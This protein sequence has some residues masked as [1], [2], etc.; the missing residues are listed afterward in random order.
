MVFMPI[1]KILPRNKGNISTQDIIH[2]IEALEHDL[3][4]MNTLEVYLKQVIQI[5]KKLNV[6]QLNNKQN[7]HT[8]ERRSSEK[9][10]IKNLEQ[11]L[12]LYMQNIIKQQLDPMQHS[13]EI[14]TEKVVHLEKRLTTLEKLTNKNIAMNE[15]MTNQ[16]NKLCKKCSEDGQP[17]IYQ[18][19]KIEKFFVDQYTQE[20]NLGNI[21]IRELSGHLNIGTTYQNH[22]SEKLTPNSKAEIDQLKKENDNS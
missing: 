16:N 10:E 22:P 20:N 17:I 1:K 6:M 12:M 21:G 5:E 14:L 4:R 15:T 13:I 11:R 19:F 8:K 3:K 7:E 18:E 9:T 2:K